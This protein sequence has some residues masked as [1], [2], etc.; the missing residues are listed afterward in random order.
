MDER[1]SQP[2]KASTLNPHTNE[3]EK[4]F[5]SDLTAI[6]PSA[7]FFSSN[8][9]SPSLETTPPASATSNLAV[10]TSLL[11]SAALT[12]HYCVARFSYQNPIN[13]NH[14]TTRTGVHTKNRL[15]F[16]DHSPLCCKQIDN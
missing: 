13:A 14:M 11:Q 15:H 10:N 2:A 7:I 4:R 9:L 1:L 3:A 16:G 12:T 8:E 5:L 6:Q